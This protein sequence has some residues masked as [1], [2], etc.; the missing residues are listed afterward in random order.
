MSPELIELH[1]GRFMKWQRHFFK[2]EW[3]FHP[4]DFDPQLVEDSYRRLRFMFGEKHA[5]FRTHFEGWDNVPEAPALVVAN[6]SGGTSIPDAWGLIMGWY[7]QFGF[8]RPIHGMAH[9]LIFALWMTGYPFSRLGVLRADKELALDV[10]HHHRRDVLVMPGGDLECWRPW[11]ERYKVRFS[12]RTGY[13]R[14]ALK[15]QVPIVPIACAGAHDTLVVLTDGQRIAKKLHFKDMFR[16]NIFPIHLSFPFG[17][18]IGPSPH[19]PPP[20]RLRFRVGKPIYPVETLSPGEEPSI[21][22]VLEMDRAVRMTM[23]GELD[24]LQANGVGTRLRQA[25]R[26]LQRLLAAA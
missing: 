4:E 7:R 9:E 16:A 26:R 22:A 18:G 24:H 23:Q 13:A 12:G 1:E 3:G 19:L 20:V 21:E 10:L 8:N 15:A 11:R 6:H 17:V 25:K 14:L 2:R 5:Y